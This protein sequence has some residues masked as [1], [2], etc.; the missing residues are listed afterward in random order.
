M[1]GIRNSS[2]IRQRSETLDRLRN[3]F[4][5][6][7]I[8]DDFWW[9]CIHWPQSSRRYVL[10]S[11]VFI[12]A[13]MRLQPQEHLHLSELGIAVFRRVIDDWKGSRV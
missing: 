13:P 12:L 8:F 3:M 1:S 10:P 7:G 9:V 11:T 4:S 6:N 2:G 5:Q